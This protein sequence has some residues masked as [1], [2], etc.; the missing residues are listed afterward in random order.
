VA[1]QKKKDILKNTDK[2]HQILSAFLITCLSPLFQRIHTVEIFK[3][4]LP[5]GFIT[6]IQEIGAQRANFLYFR[7]HVLIS[8]AEL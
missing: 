1:P 2:T 5:I 7:S 4:C 6:K 8:T 3:Q